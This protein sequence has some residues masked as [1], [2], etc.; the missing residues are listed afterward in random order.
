MKHIWEYYL[1]SNMVDLIL[2]ITALIL[3]IRYGVLKWRKPE[4]HGW[5]FVLFL[6]FYGGF[7]IYRLGQMRWVMSRLIHLCNEA[8]IDLTGI[9]PQ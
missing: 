3:A 4:S 2:W 5:L 7:L 9:I 6:C 1:Q 8:E